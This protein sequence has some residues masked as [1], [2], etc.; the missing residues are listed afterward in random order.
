MAGKLDI[1]P[2][3]NTHECHFNI[4]LKTEGRMHF[5]DHPHFPVVIALHERLHAKGHELLELYAREG[6]AQA[7]TLLK[8]FYTLRDELTIRLGVLALQ[9]K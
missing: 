5:R 7:E 4:W 3:M 8:E 6:Q 1:P 2:L 9:P